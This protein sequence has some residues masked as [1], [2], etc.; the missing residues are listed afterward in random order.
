MSNIPSI[1]VPPETPR[2]K[3]KDISNSNHGS[4]NRNLITPSFSFGLS[5]SPSFNFNSP[6]VQTLSPANFLNLNNNFTKGLNKTPVAKKHNKFLE[7]LTKSA[8]AD[9]TT[10]E[11]EE[12]SNSNSN[13]NTEEEDD[14][15]S[16]IN[17][18]QAHQHNSTNHTSIYEDE[19]DHKNA[20]SFLTPNKLVLDKINEE[21]K[22]SPTLKEAAVISPRS[23]EDASTN[24][25]VKKR[26]LS[27]NHHHD[28]TDSPN[29]SVASKIDSTVQSPMARKPS[30]A[31]SVTSNQQSS[32]SDDKVWWTE[33][34]EVLISSLYKYKK[35]K[36]QDAFNASSVLKKT[37]QNK[38][39]SRMLLNKTGVLR[40]TKQISS[41]IFRLSKSGKLI[42]DSKT[43]QTAG[44]SNDEIDDLLQT[45]LEDLIT[46]QSSTDSCKRNAIIDD[47]LNILLA[48]SPLDEEFDSIIYK[49]QVR[50][51]KMIHKFGQGFHDITNLVS[52]DVTKSV[53][54]PLDE[55]IRHKLKVKNVPTWLMTHD[56]NLN[57]NH[58][59]SSTPMSAV[60][61]TFQQQQRH[62]N[63]SSTNLQSYMTIDV[64][65]GDKPYSMLNWRSSI[66]VFKKDERLLD[67]VDVVNGYYSESSKS[68]SLQI[69]FLKNFFVG[70]I[71]FLINGGLIT[72]DENL[73]VI[74]IIYSN[75]N[76]EM[77]FVLNHSSIH[78]YIIHEFNMAGNSGMSKL[79]IV[80]VEDEYLSPVKVDKCV[81]IDDN[82]TVLA[83]SSP[84][85]FSPN[86][87]KS[88]D[89]PSKTQLKIDPSK[90]NDINIA[91]NAGPLTAPIYN[92]ELLNRK[93]IDEQERLN[94]NNQ[95]LRPPLMHSQSVSNINLMQSQNQQQ[96]PVFSPHVP[97]SQPMPNTQDMSNNQQLPNGS[98]TNNVTPY[99]IAQQSF[100]AR[101]QHVQVQQQY[102]S[103]EN[104]VPQ[105]APPQMVRQQQQQQQIPILPKGVPMQG[106]MAPQMTVQQITPQM[107]AQMGIQ[108]I[109]MQQVMPPNNEMLR[110]QWLFHQ[111]QLQMMQ[112]VPMM[113]GNQPQQVI[114]NNN[115]NNNNKPK[116]QQG[117]NRNGKEKPPMQI[118]FGPILGHD[119]SKDTRKLQKTPKNSYNHKF[120]ANS[121]VMYKPKK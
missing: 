13:S 70:Y 43:P 28:I 121:Q 48:S 62:L 95:M 120:S 42:K 88:W 49:L 97:N 20:G 15:W 103:P 117:V 75:R 118:T 82:E 11:R 105:Q 16:T 3:T 47:E 25:I 1:Q 22:K 23:S 6:T 45:P 74:Q 90:A 64:A 113:Q 10:P 46:G 63:L 67:V 61:P 55:S 96:T 111:Q 39:L 54:I 57:C 83:D 109:P 30:I 92:A 24:I 110:Q 59:S 76:D 100:M 9:S 77:K 18:S 5:F 35:F 80:N 114:V 79:N 56:L 112:N 102:Q 58:I 89:T 51:F 21:E 69:P 17:T 52:I 101:A 72:P 108:Q 119:P 87:S 8:N 38:V 81:E 85:K 60:S 26:K 14:L 66:T 93:M 12:Q 107:A 31:N 94:G 32:Q 104:Y 41:R 4:I 73:R 106:Q 115:N 53:S 91:A 19:P 34:D 40:S 99:Q 7:A 36:D 65:C 86:S 50:E 98:F 71:G 29:N 84:M 2:D 37:S 68:Y 78:A 44:S 27:F 33:L 116:G